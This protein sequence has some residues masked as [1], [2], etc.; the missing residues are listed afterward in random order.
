V[1][2]GQNT[3][4][5]TLI[6]VLVVMVIVGILATGVVFMFADPTAKV[7]AGV[8]EMR[9]DFNLARAEAVRRNNEI[10]IQFLDSAQETCS[11]ETATLFGHCF[12]GGNSQ[13]YVVC[14]NEDADGTPDDDCS[15]ED[16]EE[17][18]IKTAL[19]NELVKFY[20]IGATAPAEGPDKAPNGDALTSNNG[21]TFAGD[22]FYM[23]PNGTSADV[24]SVVIYYPSGTEI[25]GKPYAID[26]NNIGNVRL[27]RWRHEITDNPLT[28]DFDERWSRK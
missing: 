22:F 26:V 18:V 21:I 25:R 3:Y 23:N 28:V 10:L 11:K 12:A 5:Y 24:G 1:K 19:F 16:L 15:D 4:G 27:F 9:G 20:D 14:F 6:E 7:K 17:N 13:G 2:R 8:F